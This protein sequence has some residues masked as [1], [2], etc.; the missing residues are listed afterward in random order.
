MI[1]WGEMADV[2]GLGGREGVSLPLVRTSDIKR[3]GRGRF[4]FKLRK[5]K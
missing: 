2:D 3:R 1:P 5:N 4:R